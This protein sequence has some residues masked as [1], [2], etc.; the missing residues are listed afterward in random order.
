MIR[1]AREQAN[2]VAKSNSTVL[3]TGE[4]GTEKK[5]MLSGMFL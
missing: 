4:S 3:I 5:A 2:K 1:K